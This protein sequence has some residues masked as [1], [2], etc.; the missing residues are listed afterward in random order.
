[1]RV[2][3]VKTGRAFTTPV[4]YARD[5]DTVVIVTS[6]TYRW[7]R[8]IVGGAEVQVRLDGR[9]RSGHARI[10]KP[11]DPDYEAT[12][13]LQV[14]LRGP[15]VLRGFGIDVDD[16]GR[17]PVAERAVAAERTHIV[18]IDLASDAAKP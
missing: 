14:A 17:I 5:A 13:A 11:L 9:W 4:G 8:N 10:L 7:W 6:P 1:M 16:Q 15:R 3:G 18:R 12:V 2:T